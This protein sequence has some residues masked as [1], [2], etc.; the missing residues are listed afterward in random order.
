M[1]LATS[2]STRFAMIAAKINA[3][4]MR[5]WRARRRLLRSYRPCH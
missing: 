3:V 5:A 4:A 2:W 1:R